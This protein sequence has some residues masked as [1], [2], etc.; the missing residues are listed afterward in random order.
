MP[1]LGGLA[2][3]YALAAGG[4]LKLRVPFLA[5]ILELLPCSV[6][7]RASLGGLLLITLIHAVET[8]KFTLAWNEYKTA[9]RALAMGRESDLVLG[10][11]RFVSAARLGRS[12]NR[13]AWSSTTPFLSVLVAPDF[14][15]ARLVIDPRANYFWLSCETAKASEETG[16][17]IPAQSRELIRVHACLH[18]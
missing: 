14:S 6:T 11:K 10:D 4:R 15:P 1:V 12:L 18:R 5:E 13:L 17:A 7:P 9:L 3:A 8:A 2:A 16:N